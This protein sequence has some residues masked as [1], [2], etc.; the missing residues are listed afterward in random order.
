MERK[1]I[2]IVEDD[3]DSMEMLEKLVK[4][5][6]PALK[7]LKAHNKAEAYEI[8]HEHLIDVFLI[9]IILNTAVMC[10][11]SG[12]KLAEEIRT[13]ERYKFTPIVFITSLE[14]PEMYA[15]K[16]LHSYDYIE[17]PYSV[18]E[19]MDTIKGALGYKTQPEKERIMLFKK[20]GILFPIPEKNIVYMQSKGHM[21]Y[22]YEEN[23]SICIPYRSCREMVET[24][25]ETY[26]VQCNRNTIINRKFIIN[27]DSVNKYVLIKSNTGKT[28]IS[29]GKKYLNKVIE[30]MVKC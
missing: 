2:L 12:M 14:D 1:T 4:E 28:E 24:L 5:I 26:F 27:I 30:G 17:K 29:I 22:I 9:D 19:T 20:D 21:L 11:V 16:S 13:I 10:D 6:D 23:D 7:C 18:K 3:L 15:F 8:I 25:D